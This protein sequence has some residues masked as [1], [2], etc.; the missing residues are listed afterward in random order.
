MV[1]IQLRV[2][3]EEVNSLPMIGRATLSPEPTNAVINEAR[4]VIRRT[5][6]GDICLYFND[7]TEYL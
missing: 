7:F 6:L 4:V 2:N 3:A 5:L 1:D